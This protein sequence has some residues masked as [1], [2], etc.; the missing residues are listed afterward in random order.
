[1]RLV[2]VQYL[3]ENSYIAVDVVDN[4]GRFMIKGGQKIT[5]Q[6]IQILYKLGISYV[7]IQDEFC[8]HNTS[9]KYTQ[10][11]SNIYNSIVELKE[12]GERI[13]NGHSGAEDV[14]RATNIATTIVD[15]MLLLPKDFKISYEP[16][17]LMANYTI[18]IIIYVAMMSTA[19][20]VKM[21]LSREELIKLCL[22]ALLKD[23]A[24][25]SPKI[26]DASP[27]TYQTHPQIA[28]D[29][30]KATYNIDEAILQGILQHHE[31]V[32]GTG[33]PNKLKGN[34]IC[35]FAR[36]ISVIDCFYEVKS[37]HQLLESTELLFEGKL[38]QILRKFDA[39]IITYFVR[40]TEIFTL[41]TLIRL[42]NND[43]AAVHQNNNENPFNPII[44]IIRSDTY[45][46]GEIIN[47]QHSN[48]AIKNITYY[49]ED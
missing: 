23:V 14:L 40:N 5:A 18:E 38:K 32:D 19:L 42:N 47:L 4:E 9:N 26:K 6:G 29:Y 39:E 49:V 7:Y 12:I 46:E 33:Y 11:M 37:N 31:Y 44:R 36:I 48:L 17:K 20:G 13:V 30:L 8:F 24:L 34:Q 16:S 3:K 22:A 41:D 28:Y 45:P 15:E 2:P 25:L 43:I 35:T 1:M 21:N 27:V 10:N